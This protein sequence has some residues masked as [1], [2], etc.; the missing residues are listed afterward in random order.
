MKK[1][2]LKANEAVFL[3]R[4]G[5]LLQEGYSLDQAVQFLSIQLA[6]KNGEPIDTAFQGPLSR[7]EP[8]YQILS[9]LG[10]HPT[11]VS[12][13]YYGENNGQLAVMLE[14]A[15]DILQKNRKI[16]RKLAKI[17][18]YPTFLIFFTFVMMILF[19]SIILPQFQSLY[20]SFSVEPNGFLRLLLWLNVHSSALMISIILFC[21]FS[22]LIYRRWWLAITP[23]NKQV[24]LSRLPLAGSLVRYWNTYYFSFHLSE[25]LKNGI[26]LG[27]CLE[28]LSGDPQKTDLS[29]AIT[30]I[31]N[32]LLTGKDFHEACQVIPYWRKELAKIIHHGDISGT[33]DREL[34]NYSHHCL[35]MLFEKIE[36]YTQV[37]QPVVFSLI[38]LFII[39]LYISI[40][41]PTFQIIGN[42]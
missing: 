21:I 35:D 6:D 28:L 16:K 30:R 31:R 27:D 24:I 22:Y 37:L 39:I 14:T 12:F 40:L 33:L 10:F 34:F 8:F 2:W 7:G 23:F 5:R 41:L 36:R 32:V 11:A 13:S 18:S 9:S 17:L 29:M 38:G 25:L 42:I 26:S 15:G 19:Q 1:Q 3:K 20:S 4:L